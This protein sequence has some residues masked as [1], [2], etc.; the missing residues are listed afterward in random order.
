[1][2]FMVELN[3]FVGQAILYLLMKQNL[4]KN[5]IIT[6]ESLSILISYQMISVT[7]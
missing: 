5:L 1:M 6:I 3:H 2:D 4:W 7:I